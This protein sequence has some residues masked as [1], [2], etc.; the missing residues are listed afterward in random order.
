MN[1]IALNPLQDPVATNFQFRD[2]A[3]QPLRPESNSSQFAPLPWTSPDRLTIS[4]APDG[5]RISKYQSELFA[6]FQSMLNA[7]QLQT[8][9]LRAFQQWSQYS[10]I[11]VGL[12]SD[13]GVQFGV[14]G[15]EQGDSRVGDIRV[16]AIPMADDVF[17][18][19]I[20]HDSMVSG[21]WSG[22]ILF[23]SRKTFSSVA[24]FYSVVLHEAGHV[25]G[26]EHSTE[27]LSIMNPAALNSQIHSS[28]IGKIRSLYGFRR[29]DIEDIAQNN[30]SLDRATRI[31]NSGSLHGRIPL[32]V[33]GDLHGHSDIDFFELPPLSNYGEA[34]KFELVSA[35]ISLLRHKL[36]IFKENGELVSAV[37]STSGWG[38]RIHVTIPQAEDGETYFAKVEAA[39][40]SLYSFG[41]YAL[42]ATFESNVITNPALI[43][44]V[45]VGKYWQLDQTDIQKIFLEPQSFYFNQELLLNDFVDTATR[46]KTSSQHLADQH[47]QGVGSFSYANDADVYS[48]KTPSTITSDNTLTVNLHT[49]EAARI[50]PKVV[51]QNANRT[52]LPSNILVN[53]NGQ[54]VLQ[55]TNIQPNQTY[56]LRATADVSSDQYTLG[57]YQFWVRFDQQ[58]QLLS[59]LGQGTLSATSATSS[60]RKHALYVAETNML[61]LALSANTSSTRDMAQVWVTIYDSIGNPVFRTLTVPGQTRTAKSVILRP[62]SYTVFV[63][64][65]VA[66]GAPTATS[67]SY[68]LKG[69]G[70]TDPIGPE[71]VNPSTKPFPRVRP[72]DPNYVYPGNV[73]SPSTFV[74]V[75]SSATITPPSQLRPPPFVNSNAWYWYVPWLT[76]QVPRLS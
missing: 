2:G 22:D 20:K 30:D 15:F 49:M 71:L 53:G 69:I 41:S 60:S 4:F 39:D 23:N 44:R 43:E 64:L 21:T 8:Q 52:W 45:L 24:Q 40:T 61:H 46:L 9:V 62:G 29:L 5:T 65:A 34:I 17:A 72:G 6:S 14:A 19:S 25:L 11:N 3:L 74:V 42:K 16:G 35:G 36:S 47:Y 1:P 28:D 58:L 26:L 63:S 73:I 56:Y 10:A 37:T 50:V 76:S 13:S 18:V 38:S 31:K 59:T 75:N 68:V 51:I 55:V 32:I 67:L 70:I 54:L 7:Q 57:N 12:K 33:Y 66:D 27:P 48:F